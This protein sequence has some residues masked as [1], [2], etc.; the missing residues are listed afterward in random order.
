MSRF[1]YPASRSRHAYAMSIDFGMRFEMRNGFWTPEGLLTVTGAA[2]YKLVVAREC[3]SLLLPRQG[4]GILWRN[5]SAIDNEWRWAIM[6]ANP[7][8]PENE[9][10][11]LRSNGIAF[12]WPELDS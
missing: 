3:E 11:I 8:N 4:D 10:R 12:H 5:P 7:I 2:G 9:Y 6:D 1:F